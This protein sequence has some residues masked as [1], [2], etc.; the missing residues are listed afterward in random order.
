MMKYSLKHLEKRTVLRH[1][2]WTLFDLNLITKE[3]CIM[4]VN[5]VF[6]IVARHEDITK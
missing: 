6:D 3:N 1:F 5:G 2:L 4:C